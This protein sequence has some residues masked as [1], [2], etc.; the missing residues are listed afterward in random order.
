M[1]LFIPLRIRF[2]LFSLPGSNSLGDNSKHY[3]PPRNRQK[4]GS[5][6]TRPK[7]FLVGKRRKKYFNK[8][9]FVTIGDEYLELGKIQRFA[10]MLK[11]LSIPHQKSFNSSTHKK[12][13]G[14]WKYMSNPIKQI[15]VSRNIDGSV[16]L[17]RKNFQTHIGWHTQKYQHMTDPYDRKET[18]RRVIIFQS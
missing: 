7:N 18:L 14:V 5:V 17:G 15:S 11:T 3:I 10:T 8:P 2:G 16:K 9:G 4:D 1:K 13:R 12:L 6:R